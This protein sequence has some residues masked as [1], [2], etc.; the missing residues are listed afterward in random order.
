MM[1]G[2]GAGA[3]SVT[4]TAADAQHRSFCLLVVLLFVVFATAAASQTHSPYA[5]VFRAEITAIPG[6]AD[7]S[8]VTGF[9][10]VFA[11]G[12]GYTIGY[13]GELFG[14]EPNLFAPK[15]TGTAVNG[16]GVHVHAGDSCESAQRQGGHYYYESRSA[17]VEEDE[18]PWVHDS[19]SSNAQG[20][21]KFSGI[22]DIGTDDLS[23]RV[24][25][26]KFF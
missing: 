22:V 19:Y 10:Y 17:A 5:T 8:D 12:D 9:A 1:R 15:C 23:G 4:A 3:N 14:L 26:S 24:F 16:C 18:D 2:A 7:S 13:V 6:T 11:S 25:L 20:Q 21:T